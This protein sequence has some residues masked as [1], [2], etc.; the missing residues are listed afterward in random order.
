M[1]KSTKIK[2]AIVVEGPLEALPS[3]DEAPACEGDRWFYAVSYLVAVQLDSGFYIHGRFE[4]VDYSKKDSIDRAQ[5]FADKVTKAGKIDL[6]YWNRQMS[7]QERCEAGLLLDRS[8][9]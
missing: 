9:Y 7:Y 6:T 3:H 5:A 1:S 8:E 4:S 2:E